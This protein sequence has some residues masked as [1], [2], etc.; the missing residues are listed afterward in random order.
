MKNYKKGLSAI[1]AVLLGLSILAPT[2]VGAESI[3]GNN[4]STFKDVSHHWASQSIQD[5]VKNG[6]IKGYEDGTFRPDQ[7]ITRAEFITLVNEAFG[8]TE[9]APV[10]FKDIHSA[11]WFYNAIAEAKAAGYIAGYEDGTM[12]PNNQITR[13]EAAVIIAKVMNLAASQD[14]DA[15]QQFKDRSSIEDWSKAFVNAVLNKGYMTGYPDHTYQPKQLI[16]RAESVVT[17]DHALKDK[18]PTIT[19]DKAGV[20]GPSDSV[21]TINGNVVISSADVTLQ[22]TVITGNLLISQAVGDGNVYLKNVTVK[23]TTTILG[24]GMH[25]VVVE[26]STLGKVDV[27]K[28]TG[29]VRVLATGKTKIGALTLESG[30][31]LE[32]KDLQDVGFT[33]VDVAGTTPKDATIILASDLD[34]VDVDS[35][36]SKLQVTQGTIDNLQLTKQ[37][38]GILVDLADGSTINT[39]KVD[40]TAS[41]TGTGKIKKATVNVNGTSFTQKPVE[42]VTADGIKVTYGTVS[43]GGG[44]GGSSSGGTTTTFNINTAGSMYNDDYTID[45]SKII[46]NG[47]TTFGP[48]SGSPSVIHGKL[49]LNPGPTGTIYLR[50]VQADNIVVKSGAPN[51][52]DLDGVS[53]SGDLT[54][55]AN[56]QTDP[57]HIVTKGTTSITR[58]TVNSKVKL[59]L[60]GTIGTVNV[61][62]GISNVSMEVSSGAHVSSFNLQSPVSIQADSDSTID[63]VTLSSANAGVTLTGEGTVQSLNVTAEGATITVPASSTVKISQ[64]SLSANNVKLIGNIDNI[65]AI[66]IPP[67]ISIN[68]SELDPAE[69]AEIDMI[70]ADADIVNSAKDGL[71]LIYVSGDSSSSV[72]S[73]LTLP[74]SAGNETEVTWSSSQP[75]IIS[76]NGVVSRPSSDTTIILTAT[77]KLGKA[78]VTKDFNVV[79]KASASISNGPVITGISFG[80]ETTAPDVNKKISVDITTLSENLLNTKVA[81]SAK[82]KLTLNLAGIGQVGTYALEQ[83]DN[84]LSDLSIPT[85]D[86][87]KLDISKIDFG[88][89]FT[90]MRD[91]QI[92]PSVLFKDVNYTQIFNAIKDAGSIAKNDAIGQLTKIFTDIQNDGNDDAKSKLLSAMHVSMLMNTLRSDTGVDHDQVKKAILGALNEGATLN[93]Y[94]TDDVAA[95]MSSGNYSPIFTAIKN[96]SSS[97]QSAIFN[98]INLTLLFDQLTNASD[99][100]KNAMFAEIDFTTMFN[101]LSSTSKT[102]KVAVA[103]DLISLLNTLQQDNVNSANILGAINFTDIF[104]TL[105]SSSGVSKAILEMLAPLDGD[106]DKNILTLQ[107]TLT[108]DLSH[109]TNYTIQLT[110]KHQ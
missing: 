69:K 89:V 58:T 47:S 90:A 66:S 2:L 101:A 105:H 52:I 44:G 39:V 8:F 5:W 55:E 97:N 6:F 62:S 7:G 54:V 46:S 60:G 73:N 63:G 17:L 59:E 28:K 110:L 31:K 67:G 33:T 20:N 82:S 95:A 106:N 15:I 12:R 98:E 71:N 10:N 94:S 109:S 50:N 14:T 79:V 32:E 68:T 34:E 13:Q 38:N 37:S 18:V 88:S 43:T 107:A 11:D 25:S 35:N 23:G 22:N 41:F 84:T 91:A 51:S 56:G 81:V 36:S 87:S 96:T 86:T 30:A 16:T 85:F 104:N 45:N 42:V 76:S 64:L 3:N 75:N 108:D 93:L 74:L 27:N 103:N 99:T 40:S 61:A 26:N 102:T 70:K 1:S 19:F 92:D 4:P 57:V 9:K 78:Y 65:E 49:I 72:T 83:G 100:T 77:I 80:T 24:G 48:S 53:V 21:Q 29:D